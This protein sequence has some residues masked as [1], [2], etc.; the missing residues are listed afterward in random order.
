MTNYINAN[1]QKEY[2]VEL[3]DLQNS[4]KRIGSKKIG[5]VPYAMVSQVLGGRGRQ[6]PRG[7]SG[8]QGPQGPQGAQGFPGPQSVFDFENNLMIMTNQEPQSGL[9]YVDDGTNTEDGQPHLRYNVNG[10]WI[11]L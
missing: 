8:P 5:T 1:P 11:D 4:N 6:G 9:F 10:T 7:P 3:L 2:L